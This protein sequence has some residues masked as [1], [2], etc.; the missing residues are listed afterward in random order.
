M[1]Y[2]VIVAKERRSQMFDALRCRACT[3]TRTLYGHGLPSHRYVF[4]RMG[5]SETCGPALRLGNIFAKTTARIESL[6]FEIGKDAV[7]DRPRES[8]Q[9]RQLGDGSG[10]V[11]QNRRRAFTPR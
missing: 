4:G 2:A 9:R 5:L 1:V 7:E 10:T 8:S 3:H 6:A 11:V